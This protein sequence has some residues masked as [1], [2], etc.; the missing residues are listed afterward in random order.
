MG[1]FNRKHG[2][3]DV[4]EYEGSQDVLIWRHPDED[5]NDGSTLIVGPSQEAIFVKHGQIIGSL[6][7]GIHK[8]SIEKH[9]FLREIS[10]LKREDVTPYQCTI[11][12]VNKMVSM[13]IDWGTDSPIRLNDPQ[14]NLSIDISAY[15]DYAVR[16]NNAYLLLEKLVGTTKGFTQDEL[17]IFFNSLLA[18]KLCSFLADVMNEQKMSAIGT[19]QY[20]ERVSEAMTIKV[21]SVF[22]PYGLDVIH[23]LV[24]RISF[25]G[26]EESEKDLTEVRII[27]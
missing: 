11:Y 24:S 2:I 21:R 9:A 22:E 19:G 26:L 18:S 8:L 4:I 1:L 15:G 6:P 27:Y 7:S 14:Y 3:I 16:V 17:K 5:F 12:F 10:G 25:S 13:A 23:F 20:L